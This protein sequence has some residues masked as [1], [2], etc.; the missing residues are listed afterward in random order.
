MRRVWLS[1]WIIPTGMSHGDAFAMTYGAQLLFPSYTRAETE[2]GHH[3]WDVRPQ[4]TGQEQCHPKLK[5][6]NMQSHA[7]LNIRSLSQQE[8]F[9]SFQGRAAINAFAL[10]P[11][12]KTPSNTHYTYFAI[13]GTS[14]QGELTCTY[15][16]RASPRKNSTL[17]GTV[18]TQECYQKCWHQ[19]SAQ[20]CVYITGHMKQCRWTGWREHNCFAAKQWHHVWNCKAQVS[21]QG[22]G[23]EECVS[24]CNMQRPTSK[25]LQNNQFFGGM[26]LKS[27]V[28][29]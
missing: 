26:Q 7:Q 19:R 16:C 11:I 27:I 5:N 8:I 29:K 25:D 13:V 24:L 21:F 1:P 3:C 6:H 17:A 20:G 2:W 10:L 22:G 18:P 9:H 28:A 4:G 15:A 12:I 14:S 23:T